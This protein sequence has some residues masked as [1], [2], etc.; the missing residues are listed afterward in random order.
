MI[1]LKEFRFAVNSTVVPLRID[2]L[3]SFRGA[4]KMHNVGRATFVHI[5]ADA[6]SVHRTEELI[7]WPSDAYVKVSQI[8]E[9]HGVLRQDGKAVHFG[10]GDIVIY[11]TSRPYDLE[12][13]EGC[14]LLVVM[15]P[16]N[17][18][19]LSEKVLAH[20][21]AISLT[22]GFAVSAAVAAFLGELA[23]N[24]DELATR[25]GAQLAEMVVAM[26]RPVLVAAAED[27][28]FGLD[29]RTQLVRTIDAFI[30][31]HLDDPDLGPKLIAQAHFISVRYLHQLFS[32]RA[33]TVAGAIKGRRLDRAHALLGDPSSSSQPISVIAASCGLSDAAYF[34]RAFKER[35][36]LSPSAFRRTFVA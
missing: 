1:G 21:T 5:S 3:E 29:S 17:D 18:L 15:V 4:V 8:I 7:A 20:V 13:P 2:A 25:A 24:F 34:S 19:A 31:D 10:Q 30:D 6:H 28:G 12:F 26:I 22:K 14:A 36:G 35:F 16:K 27:A 11:D 23:R 33:T 9:G 32:D